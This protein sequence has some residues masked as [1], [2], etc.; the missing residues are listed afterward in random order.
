MKFTA[1]GSGY[2]KVFK[3]GVEVSKHTSEREAIEAATNLELADPASNISY[4]HEYEVKVEAA[5]AT[6]P[7]P[8]TP[9][10]ATRRLFAPSS[11][12]N[13]KLADNAPLHPN[14]ANMVKELVRQ[15]SP[16]NTDPTKPAFNS[17]SPVYDVPTYDPA[18]PY[19]GN[20]NAG[21]Y[22]SSL[23][24]VNDVNAPKVP[25]RMWQNGAPA[26]W[27]ASI[28]DRLMQ[29]IRLPVGATP[30]PGGDGHIA[31]WDQVDDI[32]VEL[33]QFR[34]EG[35]EW[36][37][38]FGG[39]IQDVSNANGVFPAFT[40][41]WGGQSESG[42]TATSLSLAGG[43]IKAKELA[44]GVI[45]HCIGFAIPEGPNKF[46][47]P[48]RRTDGG[49]QYWEG[50]NAIPAGTRFRFPKD[51]VIDP[52]WIPLVKMMVEAI[53]DYGCVVQDRA[54][55][56]CFYAENTK[57]YGVPDST[58]AYRK[59]A[60]GTSLQGWQFMNPNYFPFSKLQVLV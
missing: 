33:W 21:D 45:G 3:D 44:A 42:A 40:N 55:A 28:Y 19:Y 8:V 23:Y 25:I 4:K 39:I 47:A 59:K 24:I 20:V 49:T 51:I 56:V 43:M 31:I 26:D 46:I 53:R 11:F 5:I 48:A 27:M 13:T 29:G 32:L 14:S 50:P 22:T 37:A 1:V 10:P 52:N 2:Y 7:P 38:S 54:G 9:P 12:Y 36:R 41:K 30:N 35:G 57:Q 34:S 16:Q 17:Q 6:T 58:A 60:D 18:I 15:S